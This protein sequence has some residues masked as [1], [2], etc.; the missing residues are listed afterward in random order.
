MPCLGQ[1]RTSLLDNALFLCLAEN[2]SIQG[3]PSWFRGPV[4]GF[5]D[6]V[7]SA[8]GRVRLPRP[9]PKCGKENSCLR[10]R[11][12][13]HGTQNPDLIRPNEIAGISAHCDVLVRK[14]EQPRPAAPR[15]CR[16]VW[17]PTGRAGVSSRDFASSLM[18]SVGTGPGGSRNSMTVRMQNPPKICPKPA[19]GAEFIKNLANPEILRKQNLEFKSNNSMN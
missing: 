17:R 10:P 1:F 4:V 8:L 15:P 14:S 7:A 11:T 5:R 2:L 3:G 18:S 12:E 6:G 9:D 16:S 19:C 13:G